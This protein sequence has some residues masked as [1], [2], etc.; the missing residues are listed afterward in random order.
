MNIQDL[1]Q[2]AQRMRED[3]KK[4]QEDLARNEYVGR[5]GAGLVEVTLN[6]K[7]AAT[8]VR[9]DRGLL[10]DDP[11][12][13]EDLIAAAFNDAMNRVQEVQGAGMQQMLSGLGLPPGFK[14]PF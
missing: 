6:G 8:R 11:E 4:Q 14:F 10:A 12:M 2:Q 7:M 1:M 13:A 3:L 9:V 5:A